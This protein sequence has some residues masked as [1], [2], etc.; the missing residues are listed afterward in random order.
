MILMEEEDEIRSLQSELNEQ[1]KLLGKSAERE[2]NLAGVVFELARM[3][4][5]F[6]AFL[7][8]H[9]PK[10]GK[11]LILEYRKIKQRRNL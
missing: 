10:E 7:I 1:C 3:N 11:D 4:E 9:S 8:E 6:S 5:K 2:Y